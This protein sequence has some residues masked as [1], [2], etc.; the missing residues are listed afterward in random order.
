MYTVFWVENL[1]RRALGRPRRRRDDNI[2]MDLRE[3]WWE[4]ELY[5]HLVQDRDQ[6]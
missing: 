5:M 3:M 2:R 1:K 6:W 4:V